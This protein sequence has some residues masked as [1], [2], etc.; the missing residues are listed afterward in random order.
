[1]YGYLQIEQIFSGDLTVQEFLVGTKLANNVVRDLLS[2]LAVFLRHVSV[3]QYV[4]QS[5]LCTVLTFP[6]V[7]TSYNYQITYGIKNIW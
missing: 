4:L 1:M 5:H 2:S 3:F 6:M 7:T